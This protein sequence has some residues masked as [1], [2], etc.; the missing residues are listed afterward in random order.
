MRAHPLK[1]HFYSQHCETCLY[2]CDQSSLCHQKIRI[3]IA[4]KTEKA[5][6]QYETLLKSGHLRLPLCSTALSSGH[7]K[8]G[9]LAEWVSG[10]PQLCSPASVYRA[11]VPLRSVSCVISCCN[12][13][14]AVKQKNAGSLIASPSKTTGAVSNPTAK[15]ECHLVLCGTVWVLLE[16]LFQRTV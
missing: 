7:L 11:T 1:K 2:C 4:S 10:S 14:K 6:W 13:F 3:F 12:S 5:Y 15:E 9:N 8:G 16:P